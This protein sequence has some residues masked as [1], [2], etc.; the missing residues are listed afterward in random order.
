MELNFGNYD[1]DMA[2]VESFRNKMIA[3]PE[4][5]IV[6]RSV[7]I[8]DHPNT[9]PFIRE[10]GNHIWHLTMSMFPEEGTPVDFIL[11][12]RDIL[13]HTPNLRTFQVMGYLNDEGGRIAD[14]H[15]E[16]E[17]LNTFLTENPLP[18]LPELKTL[19][20]R[21]RDIHSH[22]QTVRIIDNA[23][24][25]AYAPQ[26][27]RLFQGHRMGL[28]ELP[29]SN[30][31]DLSLMIHSADQLTILRNLS[32][33]LKVL[34][35][36]IHTTEINFRRMFRSVEAFRET[37]KVLS[38]RFFAHTPRRIQFGKSVQMPRRI[39]LPFLEE[40]RLE[41][42]CARS[43]MS[44][45]FLRGLWGLRILEIQFSQYTKLD[46]EPRRRE[47]VLINEHLDE[48]GKGSDFGMYFSNIWELLPWLQK[49]TLWRIGLRYRRVF[50]RGFYDYVHGQIEARLMQHL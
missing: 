39:N 41:D 37:L 23:F 2:F 31:T 5:P 14:L 8:R 7:Q 22:D 25:T 20:L 40:L 38:L 10:F 15:A 34:D 27:H 11:Y 29:F 1:D 9:L 19:D 42:V 30:L 3:S 28:A 33:P 4:N 32:S 50:S 12:L 46:D 49:L 17:L 44:F 21:L 43:D 45:D 48:Y 16:E 24:L 18:S 36:I 47:R 26:L 6:S 13:S 35:L